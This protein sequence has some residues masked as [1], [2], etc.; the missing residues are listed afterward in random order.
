MV[1]ERLVQRRTGQSS[2]GP[3]A[4]EIEM[5]TALCLKFLVDLIFVAMAE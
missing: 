4:E 3:L 2:T 5:I 1:M